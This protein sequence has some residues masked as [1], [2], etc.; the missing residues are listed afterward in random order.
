MS[1]PTE[2]DYLSGD[3]QDR[4]VEYNQIEKLLMARL[5]F[6]GQES[7]LE[8]VKNIAERLTIIETHA[9][10]MEAVN[11]TNRTFAE[12]LKDMRRAMWQARSVDMGAEWWGENGEHYEMT[13]AN[14]L[15]RLTR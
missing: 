4:I 5:D 9:A 6:S 11:D 14:L 7:M 3:M 13:L 10:A 8:H 15:D 12:D 2:F 1:E